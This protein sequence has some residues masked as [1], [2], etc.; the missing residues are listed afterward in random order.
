MTSTRVSL[1]ATSAAVA[2]WA[3]KGLAISAAGGLG[4]SP[5]EGSLFL[6]GLISFVV[7][8]VALGVA[9]LPGRGRGIRALAGLGTLLAGVAVAAGVDAL[10]STF[11]PADADRH[12]A[13]TEVNLWAVAVLALLLALWLNRGRAN[14]TNEHPVAVPAA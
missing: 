12:W 4:R 10:V 14:R 6:A 13:W 5:F 8:A 1:I 7:A 11:Q 3:L 2:L 9:A